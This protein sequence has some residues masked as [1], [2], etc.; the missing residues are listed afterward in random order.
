M[1]KKP[2]ETLRVKLLLAFLLLTLITLVLS[3]VAINRSLNRQFQNYIQEIKQS[4]NLRILNA[5]TGYYATHGT[6]H[7]IAPVLAPIGI[8]T[9]TIIVLRDTQGELIYSSIRDMQRITN[10]LRRTESKH[11]L[12]GRR[13]LL[14]RLRMQGESFTYPILIEEEK[15]GTL[16]L[17]LLGREGIFA[18]EDLNFSRTIGRSVAWIAFFAALGALITSFFLS[19]SLTQPLS[20]ITRAV[21]GLQK[22]DLNQ[23]VEVTSNDELGSLASSFN[24]MAQQLAKNEKLRRTLTADISHELRTPLTT[25]K[26]YLE[27]FKDKVLP[28]TGENIAGLQEEVNRLERLVE[29]LQDLSLVETRD[30][31]LTT[32]EAN[33]A[34]VIRKV[35]ALYRPLLQEKS[36]TSKVTPMPEEMILEINE[37]S[38]ERI[39]HNLLSNAV[40][41]TPSGGEVAINLSEKKS[42]A[43]HSVQITVYNSGP[44]IEEKSLPYIFERF[45]RCDPSRSRKTGG[46][47]IG[48]TIVKELVESQGGSISVA[49]SESKGTTFTIS[50]PLRTR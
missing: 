7:G 10:I 43:K 50:F 32:A 42:K 26:S 16:E 1:L 3:G 5:V 33:P 23:Q 27:A 6:W 39:L 17:T 44:G 35:Y 40:K 36:I 28:P 31:D 12:M 20:K 19:R 37:T 48:L 49:S 18:I 24:A 15:V 13:A 14:N 41:Y 22:G 47:G 46:A 4:N 11:P 34:A 29:D 8:S 25:L 30:K 45:Y 9:E 21:S 2:R 38:L